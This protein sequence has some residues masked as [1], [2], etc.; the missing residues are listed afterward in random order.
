[1]I[2]LSACIIVRDA[3]DVLPRCLD[4]LAY[5]C[6]ELCIID[7]GSNDHSIEIARQRADH[8]QVYLGCND[9]NDKII[10]FSA[11]RNRCLELTTGDWILSI[12]ADE[13]FHNNSKQSIQACLNNQNATAA[14]ITISRGSTDWLA[15]RLFKNTPEQRYHYPV[16]ELVTVTG[17]TL[18]LRDLSIRDLGQTKKPEPSSERNIRICESVLKVNP[19]D[20]RALF[21]RAEALRKLGKFK[22]ACNAY[23]DCL[24]N[25]QLSLPYRCATFESLS[26]C[27]MQLKL[28][29]QALESAR[30][31]SLIHPGL[32]ESYCLMGDAHIAMK[33]ISEA[34]LCY[35]QAAAQQYPPKDY[36]LFVRKHAYDEYP[37]AQ[38][39]GL[40]SLCKKHGINYNAL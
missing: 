31:V 3:A 4:S 39:S 26:L 35:Q 33:R 6:D 29:D 16:H 24:E 27:F 19:T 1:M 32:A 18:T 30:N 21:Y 5:I 22:L 7:T 20:I 9:H 23:M 25:P 8:F 14:A 12:D 17:E 34:K 37:N 38:L 10:D 36:K 28:W 40:Q 15:I 2:K 11:A 13:V